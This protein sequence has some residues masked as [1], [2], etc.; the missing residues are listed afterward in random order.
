MSGLASFGA[1]GF[2]LLG[3]LLFYKQV[4]QPEQAR[5][6]QF[7]K[8]WIGR[9]EQQIERQET[10]IRMLER[11]DE[12][13]DALNNWQNARIDQLVTALQAAGAPVPPAP[14]LPAALDG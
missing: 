11:Q 1:G 10:R 2:L 8:D 6:S 9:M 7:N 12:R 4:W 13:K 14:P 3:A 5:Q